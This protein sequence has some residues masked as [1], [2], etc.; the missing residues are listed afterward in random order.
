MSL[1]QLP[2][3]EYR[4]SITSSCNMKCIYCHNEGNCTH[5]QL[6]KDQIESLIVN[7]YDLGLEQVRITGGEPLIHK[8]IYDIL[9]NTETWYSATSKSRREIAYKI[10]RK[11][12][13]N[14]LFVYLFKYNIPN[15]GVIKTIDENVVTIINKE[16]SY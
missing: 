7:S 9:E 3:N 15:V 6:S 16:N 14:H 8:D 13:K 12:D 5:S 1:L 4:I 11:Y 2:K 10:L